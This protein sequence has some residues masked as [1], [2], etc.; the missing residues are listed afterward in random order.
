MLAVVVSKLIF[1]SIN[2]ISHIITKAILSMAA[3]LV[4]LL[5]QGFKEPAGE[6]INGVVEHGTDA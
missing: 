1:L 5:I 3:Y 2:I 6:D 4:V